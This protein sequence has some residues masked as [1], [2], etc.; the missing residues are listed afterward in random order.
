[1]TLCLRSGLPYQRRLRLRKGAAY[2][3]CGMDAAAGLFS[4]WSES[5]GMVGSSSR[6]AAAHASCRRHFDRPDVGEQLWALVGW[7]LT[8]T[9]PLGRMCHADALVAL[10]YERKK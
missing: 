6:L 1:M 10:F 2:V 9:C 4:F 3:G 5:W 8:C 7:K